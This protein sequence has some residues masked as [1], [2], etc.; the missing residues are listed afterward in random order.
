MGKFIWSD[1]GRLLALSAAGSSIWAFIFRKFFWDMIGGTLGTEGIIPG[2]NTKA[3]VLITV[4]VPLLQIFTL[5]LGLL[6]A[7]L[8]A[9]LPWLYGTA[10]HRSM[11][12]R[13]ILY[14]LTGFVG[15][16]VYQTVECAVYFV[17]VSAVYLKAMLAGETIAGKTAVHSSKA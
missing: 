11:M 8:D 15:I 1:W 17:I 9:P 13:V 3:L 7:T 2:N 6:A 4:K 16:M 5:L 10:I 14:F 12:L